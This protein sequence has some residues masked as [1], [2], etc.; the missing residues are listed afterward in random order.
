MLG[1]GLFCT[2]PFDCASLRP[3]PVT[4]LDRKRR[5]HASA[6]DV[7]PDDQSTR[8]TSEI[9]L[10][11]R[12]SPTASSCAAK[13]AGQRE[14]AQR[15]R[16]D[17][18]DGRSTDRTARRSRDD[19]AGR[20][21]ASWREPKPRA[22]FRSPRDTPMEAKGNH[23]ETDPATSVGRPKPTRELP[24][25]SRPCF[26]A[27]FFSR[28]RVRQ[29]ALCRLLFPALGIASLGAPIAIVRALRGIRGSPR[30]RITKPDPA[31]SLH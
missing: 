1:R 14:P 16:G 27:A 24:P 10:R 13:V 8:L 17:E 4:V 26:C 2:I 3:Q 6:E 30:R 23:L 15:G 9:S 12:R 25:D 29:L 31:A 19:R 7:R 22:G 28:R 11:G 20:T 5:V 18:H 21:L